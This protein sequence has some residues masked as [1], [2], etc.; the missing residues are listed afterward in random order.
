MRGKFITIEGGEGSGKSA[1][2]KY[3]EKSLKNRGKNVLLTHEPGGTDMADKIRNIILH[4]NREK[5]ADRAELFLF[6]ASR[7]QHMEQKVIPALKRGRYVICDRFN[8]ST[9]AY[10]AF[11]R[12]VVD[13]K[14]IK[15]MDKLARQG[16][17]PDLVIYLD[18]DPK[19]G[20]AR[21]KGDKSKKL[22]RIDKEKLSF[23]RK[24]RSGF[25]ELQKSE[26][27]WIKIDSNKPLE[28]VFGQINEV[29][30]R[31]IG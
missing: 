22:T 15:R 25:L 26:K 13:L 2:A 4:E 19:V 11:G 18:A 23:H 7:A 24:V 17:G 12:K 10:Q 5:L 3:L 21:R 14:F 6:L 31:K 9:F 1:V 20:L 8:G 27:N 29:I 28:H 30:D 16:V